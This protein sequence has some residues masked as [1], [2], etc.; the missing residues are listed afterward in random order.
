MRQ[1]G[2]SDPDQPCDYGTGI[3]E[4]DKKKLFRKGFGKHT[5]LGLFLSKE[6][7]SITGITIAEDG[8]PGKGADFRI[9]VPKGSYRFNG[10]KC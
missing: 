5:G 4:E 10:N 9:V 1:D 6:I 3:S 8:V 7:L 2:E